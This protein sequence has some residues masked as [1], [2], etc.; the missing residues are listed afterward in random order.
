[1]TEWRIEPHTTIDKR[2][3][4]SN[5]EVDMFVDYDDVNHE[6]VDAEVR[7]MVDLLNWAIRNQHLRVK[8]GDA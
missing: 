5:G 3:L 6:T 8:V 4:V 1:M 2:F 7:E